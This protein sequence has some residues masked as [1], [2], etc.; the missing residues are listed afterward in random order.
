M[1]PCSTSAAE[2]SGSAWVLINYYRD[3]PHCHQWGALLAVSMHLLW[4]DE[5]AGLYRQAGF[6][7]VAHRRIP[8]DSP[9]PEVYTGRWFRDA[10]QWRKFKQEGALLIHGT[11]AGTALGL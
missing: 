1:K 4:A 8:D 9:A 2:P 11:K 10:D 6:T 3:N 5:W 7:G